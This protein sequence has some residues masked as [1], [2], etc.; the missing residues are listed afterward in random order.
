MPCHVSCVILL[1]QAAVQPYPITS[2]EYFHFPP[3][4]LGMRHPTPYV[5]HPTDQP[6]YYVAESLHSAKQEMRKYCDAMHKVRGLKQLARANRL[7]VSAVDRPSPP[8][9]CAGLPRAL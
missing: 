6:V 8:H 2:C 1:L 9:S 5:F 3:T 7:C 4:T